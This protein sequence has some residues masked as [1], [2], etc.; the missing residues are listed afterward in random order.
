MI[1]MKGDERKVLLTELAQILNINVDRL[2]G[3][4]ERWRKSGK[5]TV[6][7]EEEDY[8]QPGEKLQTGLIPEAIIYE[9]LLVAQEEKLDKLREATGLAEDDFNGGL[10]W[11]RRLNA[12]IIFRRDGETYVSL[13]RDA[14][15][16]TK[17]Y[18]EL[19]GRLRE[20]LLQQGSLIKRELDDE[21]QKIIEQLRRRPGF[22]EIKR[23]SKEYVILNTSI[24][25]LREELEKDVIKELT[26]EI[27]ITGEWRDKK[28]MEIDPEEDTY[29]V[30]PGRR[31]PLT[32]TIKEVREI[33]LRMGF[34]EFNGPI[35]ET[36]FVNFDMLFQP[37]DHPARDM[38][39]TLYLEKPV[40]HGEP[41]YPEFI[42]VVAEIHENGGG[43]GSTGWRYEWSR[44]EARKLLMRTHTTA[45]TIRGL[46]ENRDR[47]ELKLFSVGRVFR[48]ET[49]DYKH[50]SDFTQ[51][52]GILMH[53]K[54]NLRMLMGVLERFFIELGAKKV[55]F[56][57]TYFPFT[58]PSIQ[59][60]VYME[61][62]GEWIELGGAGIFRPEITLPMNVKH[63]V[64]AW[65]LG[66][67]RIIM[68][69]HG[70]KDIREIYSNRLDWL[71][72]RRV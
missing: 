56:W 4:I 13:N 68:I 11:L 67:E 35:I 6:V 17:R 12:L 24:D 48:N 65:G 33:F 23:V 53:E 47:D 58:E 43:T 15:E 60:T 1:S 64:L 32:E 37:Q 7:K 44:E 61:E 14:V 22:I 30:Y 5:V 45:V 42:D 57:P 25:D 49:I 3:Y 63:P 55:R 40:T 28:I 46:Y 66:L 38:H 2:R 72:K 71:R 31:H 20:R 62:I 52:D 26:R 51:V 41:P 29:R 8:I 21:E 10:A 34:E 27:L 19:L 9:K 50:L 36:A 59:P 18:F 16:K 54:A 39:D 70:I 69:R